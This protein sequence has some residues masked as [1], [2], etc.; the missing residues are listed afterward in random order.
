MHTSSDKTTTVSADPASP[1][2]RPEDTAA[3][4]ATELGRHY[5]EHGRPATASAG[6]PA[7]ESAHDPARQDSHRGG[8][9]AGSAMAKAGETAQD[10]ASRA[11]EQVGPAIAKVT[12]TAQDLAHRAR[13][14]AGP[15]AQAVYDQGARA[16]QYVTQNVHQYPTTAL[17]LAAALG[18]GLAYLIHGGGR[19]L[20]WGRHEFHPHH[21]RRGD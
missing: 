2:N 11:R 20:R 13:E 19:S 1:D 17:L 16:G 18:Y 15:A 5:G 14:Q 6:P 8:E 10:L 3:A 7:H 9:Q 4:A 21:D 12:E